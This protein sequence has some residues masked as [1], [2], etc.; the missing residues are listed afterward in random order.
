MDMRWVY[1]FSKKIDCGFTIIDYS[2]FLLEIS[3]H[4]MSLLLFTEY[5]HEQVVQVSLSWIVSKI[6]ICSRS[7]FLF[8]NYLQ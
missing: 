5:V 4:S 6:K 3:G 2:C 1:S 7:V 8:K